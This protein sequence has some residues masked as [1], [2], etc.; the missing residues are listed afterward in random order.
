VDKITDIVD[1]CAAMD[2]EFE[3]DRCQVVNC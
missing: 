2:N 1:I 3:R